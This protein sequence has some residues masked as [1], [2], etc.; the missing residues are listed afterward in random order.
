[1]DITPLRSKNI[2]F[3]KSYGPSGL[4]IN[5]NTISYDFILSSK[6]IE[7]WHNQDGV[8]AY[9]SYSRLFDILKNLDISSISPVIIIGTGESC[10]SP[11]TD[12]FTFFAL[13]NIMPE[14]MSTPSA[15]RT[16]NVLISEGR[17][18]FGLFKVR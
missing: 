18:V 9:V 14:V 12:F 5:D 11:P 2:N 6:L 16:F 3:I 8:F 10:Q 4:K 7:P 1:M 13:A 15:A 17:E